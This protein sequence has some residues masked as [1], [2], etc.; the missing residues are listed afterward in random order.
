MGG[1]EGEFAPVAQRGGLSRVAPPLHGQGDSW[2]QVWVLLATPFS[3]RDPT[4]LPALTSLLLEEV[5]SRWLPCP[6]PVPVSPVPMSQFLL[7]FTGW[8]SLHEQF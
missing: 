4:L 2:G 5:G 7:G 8:V 6:P 1:I 3:G